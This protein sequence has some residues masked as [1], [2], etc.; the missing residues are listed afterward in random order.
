MSKFNSYNNF[1]IIDA[2]NNKL[3]PTSLY[4]KQFDQ[5]TFLREIKVPFPPTLTPKEIIVVKDGKIPSKPPNSFIIYRRAFQK[6]CRESGYLLKLN[7]V[8]AMAAESWKDEPLEVKNAY[9]DLALQVN[10]VLVEMRARELQ[11]KSHV[12]ELKDLLKQNIDDDSFDE[13][14][15]LKTQIFSDNEKDSSC[16]EEI[17]SDVSLESI[18]NDV[19]DNQENMYNAQENSPINYI[20]PLSLSPEFYLNEEGMLFDDYIVFNYFSYQ[21]NID[22]LNETFISHTDDVEAIQSQRHYVP[23]IF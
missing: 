7:I 19:Y 1:I 8:S 15:D 22:Q 18:T 5:E 14:S 6:Q 11:T 3:S 10:F 17:N 13:I 23:S 12:R 20:V 9:K 2:T 4:E 16:N 21:G